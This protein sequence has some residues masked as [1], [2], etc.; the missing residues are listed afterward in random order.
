MLFRAPSSRSVWT[1]TGIESCRKPAVFVKSR[2][3]ELRR[4]RC[5]GRRPSAEERRG[6]GDHE[7]GGCARRRHD[8]D[9][10]A[11]RAGEETRQCAA[12][13]RT[14]YQTCSRPFHGADPPWRMLHF[15]ITRCEATL[16]GVVHATIRSRPTRSNASSI[17]VVAASD[18][19][20]SP[21]RSRAIAQPISS[22]SSSSTTRARASGR[23]GRRARR[24]GGRPRRSARRRAPR[25]SARSG[26]SRRIASSRVPYGSHR[27]T[28]G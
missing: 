11:R 20:P 14:S 21:H 7:D 24:S 25:S 12:P 23:R 1:A 17:A 2:M 4:R 8:G 27:A 10:V 16:S 22:F 19:R 28:S 13:R 15:S 5:P 26:R 18:A 6:D 9:T 3:P